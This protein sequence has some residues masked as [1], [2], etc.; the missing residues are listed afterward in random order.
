M[1]EFRETWESGKE[2]EVAF[3]QLVADGQTGSRYEQWKQNMLGRARVTAPV[4]AALVPFIPEPVEDAQVVD[5]AAGPVSC[6]GWN[7]NG[8]RI[9]VTPIDALAK[10]YDRILA[11]ADILPAVRTLPGEAEQIESMFAP[12]SIDLV[13]VRNALDH[14]YDVPKILD[15]ALAVLKPGG[16]FVIHSYRDEA[17]NEKYAGFHQWNLTTKDG[18][19][20]VHRPGIW[21]DV[22]EQL[23]ARASVDI[24]KEDEKWIEIA[25]RKLTA[26]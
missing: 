12:E 21:F 2:S 9:N 7:L 13:Y 10:D 19:F 6:V 11:N 5:L 22:N 16:H 26:S 15:A 1:S 25:I 3:W 18:H 17:E 8:K 20:I 24:L 4:M 14:C 23:A